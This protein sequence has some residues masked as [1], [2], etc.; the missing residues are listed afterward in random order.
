VDELRSGIIHQECPRRPA[1]RMHASSCGQLAVIAEDDRAALQEVKALES[2]D[3]RRRR[4][5]RARRL[6]KLLGKS[7]RRR[8]AA[9]PSSRRLRASGRS[10]RRSLLKSRATPFA[11][12]S[13]ALKIL[14]S[15]RTARSPDRAVSGDTNPPAEAD[16]R[17]LVPFDRGDDLMVQA[18][19]E[20]IRFCSSPASRSEEPV[21][22]TVHRMNT[23]EQ[24]RQ[25][26]SELKKARS[27]A[28][29]CS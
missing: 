25:A 10:E 16:N 12:V 28:A 9:D 17:S 23:Q 19:D 26:F 1:G 4:H 2:G 11:Y 21:A 15:V 7:P 24:L 3:Q 14:Q 6:R 5:A 18:G 13:R 8:I 29:A 22:C 27:E 20:G